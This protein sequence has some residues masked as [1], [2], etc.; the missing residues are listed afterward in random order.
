MTLASLTNLRDL[1]CHRQKSKIL[2][3]V[4]L[5]TV[6]DS[7]INHITHRIAY[8]ILEA[9][10][11][12]ESSNKPAYLESFRII[13]DKLGPLVKSYRSDLILSIA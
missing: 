9:T 7:H 11:F 13:D 1:N 8:P 2:L 10:T 6:A 12:P 3:K 4:Y 5:S